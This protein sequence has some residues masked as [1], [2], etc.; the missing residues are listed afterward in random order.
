VKERKGQADLDGPVGWSPGII[1]TG[2]VGPMDWFPGRV[3]CYCDHTAVRDKYLVECQGASVC[4]GSDCSRSERWQ[5]LTL[6]QAAGHTPSRKERFF[7]Y[8][9]VPMSSFIF[10]FLLRGIIQ[11]AT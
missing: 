8:I 10:I 6:P 11:I 4:I 3:N 5:F 9:I 2:S 1:N 7:L